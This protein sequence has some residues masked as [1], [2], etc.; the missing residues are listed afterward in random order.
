MGE[1]R[2]E[3]RRVIE[4]ERERLKGSTVKLRQSAITTPISAKSE[5]RKMSVRK[6]G[7]A[8]IP[9]RSRVCKVAPAK[10]VVALKRVI[11]SIRYGSDF[12][13]YSEKSPG[14]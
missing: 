6:G 4:K 9:K 11:D 2:S 1:K 12:S 5:K 10:E 13:T 7:V 8:F 14:P 3:A